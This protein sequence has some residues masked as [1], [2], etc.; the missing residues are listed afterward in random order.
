[1]NYPARPE[2][3]PNPYNVTAFPKP[4][5]AIQAERCV[6]GVVG[7]GRFAS[8]VVLPKLADTAGVSLASIT[9]ARGLSA[10]NA[11]RKH[12][13]STVAG[14]ASAIFADPSINAVLI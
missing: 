7:S 14:S 1:M 11:A 4:P 8:T 5:A 9:S 12:G 10:E 13:F 6:I 3:A 2:T